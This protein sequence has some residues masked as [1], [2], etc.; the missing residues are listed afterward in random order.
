ML[1]LL[2]NKIQ[3]YLLSQHRSRVKFRKLYHF[4]FFFFLWINAKDFLCLYMHERDKEGVQ[5]YVHILV[6]IIPA[7]WT[8][9]I[10]WIACILCPYWPYRELMLSLNLDRLQVPSVFSAPTTGLF[11]SGRC[12]TL[13]HLELVTHRQSIER[14][15]VGCWAKHK[16][17]VLIWGILH[18][19]CVLTWTKSPPVGR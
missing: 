2:R 1:T 4:K 10:H 7:I 6:D 14:L 5:S 19:E 9:R 13:I 17:K 16:I 12:R 15:D 8:P 18:M 11:P 3:G